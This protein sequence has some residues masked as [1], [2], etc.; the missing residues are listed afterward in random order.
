MSMVAYAN[1]SGNSGV[2]AYD[3]GDEFIKVR[4]RNVP[5][6]Y[7]YDYTAPGRSHVE[8]MKKF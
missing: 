2:V 5:K 1:Q 8:K 3:L 4:F 7:V 6:T